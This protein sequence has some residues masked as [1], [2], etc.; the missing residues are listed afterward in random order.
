MEGRVLARFSRASHF[1]RALYSG[2]AKGIVQSEKDYRS[3][4]P[5]TVALGIY[6]LRAD[7]TEL[8]NLPAAEP[9]RVFPVGSRYGQTGAVCC[10][11]PVL[12]GR[13]KRHG[14][15]H[16][17]ASDQMRPSTVVELLLPKRSESTPIF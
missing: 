6:N 5:G 4:S 16:T 2:N 1:R 8:N 10:R 3:W 15:V 13:S 14:T 12:R 17:M 9:K 7:R 11:G